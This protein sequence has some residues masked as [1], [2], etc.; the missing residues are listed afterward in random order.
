MSEALAE[1]SA[2]RV[3]LI[4]MIEDREADLRYTEVNH[5][6]LGG[7]S[8]Y[9]AFLLIAAHAHRHANQIEEMRAGGVT[10][11]GQEPPRN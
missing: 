7:I 1:L 8:G 2:S 9:E 4:E 6:I 10:D 11:G 5:P 3:R